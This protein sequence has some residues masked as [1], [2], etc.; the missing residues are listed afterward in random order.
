ML[1]PHLASPQPLLELVRGHGCI[2]H[3][4]HYV[5]DVTIG[6]D[7][8]RLRTGKAPHILAALRNLVITPDESLGLLPDC[9]QSTPFCFPSK[10][11]PSPYCFLP[12]PLS[13]N[14][15]ALVSHLTSP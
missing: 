5:R 13:E 12:R 10:G 14:S 3:S 11:A 1:P 9:R 15:Q 7:R 4:L 2:E 8:S 6:C